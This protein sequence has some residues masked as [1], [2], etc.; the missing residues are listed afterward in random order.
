MI[1]QE[2]EQK[3]Q[4]RQ[5]EEL[6][7][8]LLEVAAF[9]EIDAQLQADVLDKIIKELKVSIKQ[10]GGEWE[11]YLSSINKTEPDLK[12]Q[13]LPEAQKRI[14]IDAVIAQV[15]EQ[16][17][18]KGSSE[19]IGAEMNNFLRRFASRKQAQTQID[20]GHQRA[21]VGGR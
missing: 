8:G 16:A 3:E 1:T 10:Q 17:G 14:K 5:E 2:Q 4:E 7:S 6:W 12:S 21:S 18:L 15:V 20:L 13:L 9:S 19:Q 11:S